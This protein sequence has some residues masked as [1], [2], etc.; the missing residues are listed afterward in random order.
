MRSMFFI[1]VGLALT[2]AG[3]VGSSERN[4]SVHQRDTVGDD[5]GGEGGA[6]AFTYTCTLEYQTFSP[7]WANGPG[8]QAQNTGAD[9]PTVLAAGLTA[10]DGTYSLS[11]QGNPDAPFNL[12]FNAT[13]LG[14]N[15]TVSYVVL[16]ASVMTATPFSFEIGGAIPPVNGTGFDGQ[17]HSF[18]YL[19]GYCGPS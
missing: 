3:C 18:D 7:S 2:L 14:P 4:T 11:I 9:A 13:L 1:P 5:A 16:P 17:P 8:A 10:S 15:G 12:S 6:T 19:R